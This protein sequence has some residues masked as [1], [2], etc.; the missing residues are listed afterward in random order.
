MALCQSEQG[1]PWDGR[2]K[3]IVFQGAV[4]IHS[5][6]YQTW[7]YEKN[8]LYFIYTL[9]LSSKCFITI[10]RLEG[11]K[12]LHFCAK[13][14]LLKILATKCV[15]DIPRKV[16]TVTKFVFVTISKTV[17]YNICRHTLIYLFIKI[18]GCNP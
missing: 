15:L 1:E 4:I 3:A 10:V 16:C 9:Y 17:P 5:A 2:D 8:F 13:F 18:P 7:S 6:W 12:F 14:L 11:I